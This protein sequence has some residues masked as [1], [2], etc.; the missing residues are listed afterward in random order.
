VIAV[1]VGDED[2][3]DVV[4]IFVGDAGRLGP[5]DTTQAVLEQRVHQDPASRRW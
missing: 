3:I 1:G 4:E 5:A 2:Q